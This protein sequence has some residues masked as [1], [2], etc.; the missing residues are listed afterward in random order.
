ML[1]NFANMP[2]NKFFRGNAGSSAENIIGDNNDNRVEHSG[3]TSPYGATNSEDDHRYE[4]LMRGN[5]PCPTCKG[6]GRIPK[7]DEAK[8]VALIPYGDV[9]LKPRRTMLWVSLAVLCCAVISG[10]L[11]FFL[12]PREVQLHSNSPHID[13]SYVYVNTTQGI[14]KMQLEN[15]FNISNKN[16]VKVVAE[17]ITMVAM[18]DTKLI[19]E[20]KLSDSVK[21]GL[22][23]EET[24]KIPMNITFKDE[25]GYIALFCKMMGNEV[26]ITF[27]TTVDT[28]YLNHVEQVSLTTFQYVNCS[29]TATT[30]TTTTTT[31]STTEVPVFE[32]TDEVPLVRQSGS[33]S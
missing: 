22:R 3:R 23:S 31:T 10:L 19:S 28:T 2:F 16:F 27:M 1:K 29:P 13:P 4:E 18:Y 7:E 17:N 6:S 9:R 11:I 25:Q 15:S 26:F 8:L 30:T 14:V 24:V 32:E 12:I 5:V 20:S 21:I 33:E